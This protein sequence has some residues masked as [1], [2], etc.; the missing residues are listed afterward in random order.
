MATVTQDETRGFFY[1]YC[2]QEGWAG[3]A[4]DSPEAAEAEG[5]AH[6]VLAHH[7]PCTSCK[8]PT[9]PLA[10]FPGGVCLTCWAKTPEGRRMPTADEVVAMWGGKR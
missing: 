5:H 1:A 8:A 10:L 3:A 7:K 2:G 9:D 6:D 4:W